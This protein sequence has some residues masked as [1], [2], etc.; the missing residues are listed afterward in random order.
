MP[1]NTGGVFMVS[2]LSLR[3]TGV[4]LGALAVLAAAAV[5]GGAEASGAPAKVTIDAEKR[6][7][8]DG[9]PFFLIGLY[10]VPVNKIE[11]AKE[12]GFNTVH[13]Y[14]GEGSPKK[15]TAASPEKLKA[16]LEEVEK[17]G[18]KAWIGL[19]RYQIK[20][21]QYKRLEE[22]VKVLKDSPA[23]LAWYLFDEPKLQ[24]VPVGTIRAVGDV[25]K[26]GDPNHPTIL[27]P[28]RSP[29]GGYMAVPDVLMTWHY[30]VKGRGSDLRPVGNQIRAMRKHV[31]DKKPVWS[32]IQLHGKG[33]GGKGYGYLEP[34]WKQVR[35][36]AYQ[37][38]VVGARGLTFFTYKGSQ[39]DLSKS[40]KGMENAKRITGE[41][42]TL[43][44]VLLS[45][46]VKDPP[47]K[48]AKNRSLASRVYVHGGKVTM[49]VVNLDRKETTVEISAVK[50]GVPGEATVLF[51]KRTV[52]T[53]GD[54]LKE[55][56]EPIGVRVY[57]LGPANSE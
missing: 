57:D 55:T 42:R 18:L 30:P 22:R 25:V 43:S 23:L 54:K 52:K 31:A 4:L 34:D 24:G 20:R 37:A 27:A 17:Q 12:L 56:I 2:G 46:A 51:E 41:L 1:G 29:K 28:Y 21:K 10:S 7:V 13:T 35:N 47:V 3:R 9:K 40:P 38:I 44:P 45:A 11:H 14:S 8:V 6:L 16:W 53:A 32:V 49:I 5:C 36:M 15:D 50:G 33:P 39:F 19:P 26:K 48:V